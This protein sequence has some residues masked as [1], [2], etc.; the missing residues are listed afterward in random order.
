MIPDKAPVKNVAIGFISWKNFSSF[1]A[2]WPS[3]WVT[4]ISEYKTVNIVPVSVSDRHTPTTNFN[5]VSI[6]S[7]LCLFIELKMVV[8]LS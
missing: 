8:S 2:D 5:I 7:G 1:G 3:G 6:S 4:N